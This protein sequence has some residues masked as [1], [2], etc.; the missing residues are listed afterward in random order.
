MKIK[1]F[2][3]VWLGLTAVFLTSCTQS[4][5]T[6][7]PATITPI[8]EVQDTSNSMV[9]ETTS[10]ATWLDGQTLSDSQGNV[11]VSVT[12]LNLNQQE[13]QLNF[14]VSM[15]THSVDLSMDLATLATLNTNNDQTINAIVWD[16]PRGGHHIL[17]TLSFPANVDGKSVFEDISTLTLTIRDVDV[18]ERIFTWQKK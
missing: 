8:S 9:N 16:A 11:T 2:I 12:P 17:G 14:E 3:M 15:N 18:P 4:N 13:E 6:A 10:L 5:T 1:I 7:Q